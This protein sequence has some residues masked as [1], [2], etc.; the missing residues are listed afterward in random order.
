MTPFF[1]L[2]KKLDTSVQFISTEVNISITV[3]LSTALTSLSCRAG[4]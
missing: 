4:P 3:D 2:H 1:D